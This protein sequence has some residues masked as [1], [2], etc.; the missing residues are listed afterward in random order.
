MLAL[1]VMALAAL[2]AFLVACQ[3]ATPTV[4]PSPTPTL[5]PTPTPTATSSPSPLPTL[6]PTAT[7]STPT[8]PPAGPTPRRGGTLTVASR[9]APPS[10]DVHRESSPALA[11]FGPGI[12][13]SRLLRL[14]TGP[15]VALP[16]LAVE[17]DL[18]A[19][20]QQPDSLTWVFSL[21]PEVR[22]QDRAPVLGRR[23]TA[24]DVVAS[25][26]RQRTPGWP[27]ASLLDSIAE[28]EAVDEVTVRLRLKVPDADFLLALASGHSKVLPQ[29]L[30]DQGDLSKGP[31]VGSG[32]WVLEQ[33]SAE[34]FSFRANPQYFEAGLPYLERLNIQVIPDLDAR[35]AALRTGL[36]DADEVPPER[37]A[38]FSRE[39]PG[40]RTALLPAPGT[41]V[42]VVVKA[43]VAPFTDLRL[44]QALFL[45]LDPWE[46][47][48]QVWGPLAF[49]SAGTPVVAADWLLPE[50]ELRGY[51]AAPDR[52]REFLR[53]AVTGKVPV[54]VTV[55]DY[56]DLS[57]AYG[58]HLV[59][60]LQVAGFAATAQVLNPRGY[61]EQVWQTGAFQVAL[62]PPPPSGT[63]NA[64]LLAVAH[65]QGRWNTTS[66]RAPELDRLIEA[67]AVELEPG[68]RRE[69]VQDAQ[70]RLL[71]QGLRF[72]PAA[73]RQAWAWWPR[74]RDL[75]PNFADFEYAFWARV[76]LEQ[77]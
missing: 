38:E 64:Y 8:T 66:Y 42:G 15:D 55:A 6:S 4:V 29:E 37:W 10:L 2:L 70:R 19:G 22:F 5:T 27:Q 75:Y 76:W 39:R 11:A 54:E 63:P 7:S 67:Q 30:A 32:P 41:G 48:Q 12:A 43:G 72:M 65:S 1:R 51:L 59:R 73:Q 52:A 36:V 24:T 68:K 33:R 25:Y 18:C 60:Q 17:C 77:G 35:L 40:M 53:Q 58:N 26:R 71:E 21:R 50:A 45:A 31:V 16:S 23:V 49:V 9:V 46:A 61:A 3:R 14:T 57:V 74:V 44:R 47:N 28:M 20:W 56:G 69:L 62:G 34:G 13:Y